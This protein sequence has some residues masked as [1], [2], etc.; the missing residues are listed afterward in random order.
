M[1][2]YHIEVDQYTGHR[3]L[4]LEWQCYKREHTKDDDIWGDDSCP[5]PHA[6]VM[7]DDDALELRGA[8]DVLRSMFRPTKAY[9][10]PVKAYRREGD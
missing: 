6:W 1:R 10:T 2:R 7:D 3:S 5:Y 9:R 4:N 8:A